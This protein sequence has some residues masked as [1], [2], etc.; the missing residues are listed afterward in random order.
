MEE[1]AWGNVIRHV[2][3]LG[4][5]TTYTYD[6]FGNRKTEVTPEGHEWSWTWDAAGNLLTETNP[7]GETTRYDWDAVGQLIKV[8]DPEG[9]VWQYTY[10]ALGNTT[11]ID[12]DNLARPLRLTDPAGN[13]ITWTWDANFLKG[14]DYPTY[15]QQY[16][17]NTRHQLWQRVD[18]WDG[19]SRST[20][21]QRNAEG[22][23]TAMTDPGG[24]TTTYTPDALG[25][26]AEIRDALG[27]LTRIDQRADGQPSEVTDPEGHTTR[28]EYDARGL[29]IREISAAGTD[30]E[31]IRRYDYD[32]D[33]RLTTVHLPDGG[34]KVYTWN[35]ADRLIRADYYAPGADAPAITHTWDYDKAGRLTGWSAP[36]LSGT[37]TYNTL[38]QRTEATTHYGA[39][40]KTLKYAYDPA[41]RPLRYTSAENR[42]TEYTWTA[43]GQPDSIRIEGEGTV[44]YGP[45]LWNRPQA[46]Q[47]PGGTRIEYQYDGLQRLTG[48]KVTDPVS[49][50]LQQL[51]YAWDVNDLILQKGDTTYTYDALYR[52]T[53]AVT[54]DST[55]TYT[56]DGVGNRLSHNDDSG[57]TY[58]AAHQLTER[59]GVNYTYNANGHLIR[60]QY[61]NGIERTYTYDASERLIRIEENGLTRAEFGYDPFGRRAFKRTAS[62]TTWYLYSEQ[63]LAAEYDD[64]GNLIAEYH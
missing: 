47:L 45:Y 2:D 21:Y 59:P 54:G 41:G 48:L 40:S 57:W 51:T 44:L 3:A 39:F 22:D 34:R 61:S 27:G 58:N 55:D 28:Y 4:N 5:V 38:G 49:Q 43:H 35:A 33:G 18:E 42:V 46:L 1:D 29:L 24:H 60:A 25:R 6:D 17:Y 52:L 14:M 20:V 37:Y 7:L 26:A 16:R 36:G 62:G 50:L 32:A 19:Q 53:E 11:R 23:L 56:Y 8:T 64:S 12:L 10:N 30:E 31:R 15:R 9:V 63:G 13:L